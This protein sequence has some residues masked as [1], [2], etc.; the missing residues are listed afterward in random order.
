M[1]GNHRCDPSLNL[2]LYFER[3]INLYRENPR[4]RFRLQ[5]DRSGRSD[6]LYFPKIT[7]S[8]VH[9]HVALLGILQTFQANS[10]FC[11]ETRKVFVSQKVDRIAV[12]FPPPPP[13]PPP[14]PMPV[15][16]EFIPYQYGKLILK[17][18]QVLHEHAPRI[19]QFHAC[20][21]LDSHYRFII[22]LQTE[23]PPRAFPLGNIIDMHVAEDIGLHKFDYPESSVDLD[24]SSRLQIIYEKI[25]EWKSISDKVEQLPKKTQRSKHTYGRANDRGILCRIARH[26]H[27]TPSWKPTNT[28]NSSL[29]RFNHFSE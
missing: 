22:I 16:K 13:A 20:G 25:K 7:I 17:Y 21:M 19:W 28:S 14:N 12:N 6:S 27:A 9:E 10:M 5:L 11:A 8:Q 24:T 15:S 26:A 4:F 29:A 3:F 18:S 2:D 1:S 23:M